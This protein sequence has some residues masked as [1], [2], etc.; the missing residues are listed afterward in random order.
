LQNSIAVLGL[1][2]FG[3]TIA[4]EFGEQDYEVIAVDKNMDNVNQVEPYVVQA[5]QGDFTKIEL[6]KEIG[7]S[8]CDVAVIGTGS[9]LESSVLAI[10]ACKK[11]EIPNIV[12]KS[13]YKI[14]MEIMKEI[15]AHK[16]I[17][18][19]KEMGMRFARNL[20][21]NHILDVIELDEDT[22]I[23][24]FSPPKK[25]IGKTISQLNIRQKYDLNIIGAR[26]DKQKKINYQP[27]P[28]E[29]IKENNVL[30]ALGEPDKFEHL[31]YTNQLK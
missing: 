3:S 16:I 12:A 20:M 5:V 13:K 11:L 9:D 18:P 27:S 1:G 24:E 29:T 28:E 8:Q 26:E 6:L 21:R 2:T 14:H 17:R 10:M 22:A 4:K 25:W 7:V 23:I 31:D 30:L 15:G 19:E